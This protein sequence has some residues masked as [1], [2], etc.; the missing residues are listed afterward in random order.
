M[1]A[2][3][4][5]EVRPEVNA[6]YGPDFDIRLLSNEDHDDAVDPSQARHTFHRFRFIADLALEDDEDSE[7]RVLRSLLEWFWARGIP[8]VAETLYDD[9]LPYRGGHEPGARP[10][11]R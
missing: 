7:V 4:G 9:A 8:A 6:L 10:W 3:L 2:H 1:G 11:A 5:L